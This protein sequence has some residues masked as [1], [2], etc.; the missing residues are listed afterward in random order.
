MYKNVNYQWLPMMDRNMV[1]GINMVGGK[2]LM[3]GMG[4]QLVGYLSA[5]NTE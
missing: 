5:I 2:D 4:M 3:V 1:V